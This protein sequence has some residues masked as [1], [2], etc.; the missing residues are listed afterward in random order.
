MALGASLARPEEARRTGRESAHQLLFSA[1]KTFQPPNACQRRETSWPPSLLVKVLLQLNRPGADR[2]RVAPG[3]CLCHLRDLLQIQ[4]RE[5]SVEGNVAVRRGN[6]QLLH[7]RST[8]PRPSH[9]TRHFCGACG[10]TV[11]PCASARGC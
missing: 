9:A 8:L 1:T 3:G 7:Y 6:C 2:R 11:C 5:R 4:K 10:I